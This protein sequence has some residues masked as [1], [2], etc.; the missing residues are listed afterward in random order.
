M[1]NVLGQANVRDAL[2]HPGLTAFAHTPC[3]VSD[4]G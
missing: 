2:F 4:T 3:A 1:G